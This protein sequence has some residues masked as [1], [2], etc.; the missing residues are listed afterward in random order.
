MD[1]RDSIIL[2]MD[3][4]FTYPLG[5]KMTPLTEADRQEGK[6]AMERALSPEIRVFRRMKSGRRP[7]NLGFDNPSSLE[8]VY[9][10][11][12]EIEKARGVIKEEGLTD[13]PADH[14]APN[15][16]PLNWR[17]RY[18][19]LNGK[20]RPTFGYVGKPR[21]SYTLTTQLAIELLKELDSI[22]REDPLFLAIEWNLTRS[23]W[24]EV[25]ESEDT[26]PPGWD[27][28]WETKFNAYPD[29]PSEITEVLAAQKQ[30]K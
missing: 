3:A 17:I 22:A 26:L 14:A 21:V 4:D 27:T 5:K 20:G 13:D 28:D 18:Y 24:L 6:K 9:R 7:K 1:K 19:V 29:K 30:Q 15:Y 10:L 11:F 25:E 12:R 2:Y 8:V 16:V 23:V